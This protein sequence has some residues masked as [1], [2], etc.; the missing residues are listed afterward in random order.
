[1][2]FYIDHERFVEL[3]EVLPVH[4]DNPAIGGDY[5]LRM[6]GGHARWSIHTSWRDSATLLRLQRGEPLIIM[7]V[8]DAEARGITDDDDVRVHNDTGTFDLKAKISPAVRR[9]QVIVYHGWEPFQFKGG[10]SH[11]QAIAS[12]INPIQLVGG[13][14]HLQPMMIMGEPG[15][16]DRGTRV[17]V[18][19]IQAA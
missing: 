3:G 19:R 18:E 6:T 16:S 4:K 1:M 15:Q 2:Q 14:Y 10:R 7:G 9:G 13:Y 17:D 11:Q 8:K 12:P 5:P